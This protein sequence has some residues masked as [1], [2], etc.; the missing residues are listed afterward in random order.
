MIR[1]QKVDEDIEFVKKFKEL[2]SL[3][4]F[5]KIIGDN[6]LHICSGRLVPAADEAL[7]DLIGKLSR[8]DPKEEIL[9]EAFR[10]CQ[11]LLAT[12]S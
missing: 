4:V 5:S 9:G 7:D 3:P 8:W 10:V 12:I 1:R 11:P 6:S 2:P